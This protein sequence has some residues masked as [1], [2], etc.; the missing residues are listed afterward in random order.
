MSSDSLTTTVNNGML[1]ACFQTK[2]L[3]ELSQTIYV[4]ARLRAVAEQAHDGR[5]LLDF[6]HVEFLD[7]SMLGQ[8]F[9]LRKHCQARN[10]VVK[11][12]GLSP[13]LLNLFEIVRLVDFIEVYKDVAEALEQFAKPKLDSPDAATATIPALKESADNGDPQACFDL[14]CCLEDGRGVEQQ[15]DAAFELFQKAADSGLAAAQYRIGFAHAYGVQVPADY[16]EA[17]KWYTLAAEQGHCDAQYALGMA[18]QYELV[19]HNDPEA[20]ARWYTLAAD[21]GHKMAKQEL[22][23]K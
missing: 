14:A 13:N 15:P 18:H 2:N 17:I 16:D 9:A 7:S 22:K 4:G 10:V 20:A 8:L 19:A 23:R 12:C 5:M 21:Q 11:A 1:V 3:D 6:Q